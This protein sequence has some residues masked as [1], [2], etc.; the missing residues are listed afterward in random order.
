MRWEQLF[1]DLEAQL[2]AAE[3]RDQAA[4][5]ADRTR[6]ERS[7]VGLGE[8]LLGQRDREVRLALR[9]GHDVAGVVVDAG[10]GWVLVREPPRVAA[11]VPLAAVEL[12]RG[13]SG[14]TAGPTAAGRAAA[15]AKRFGLGFALRALSRD[16]A[17]VAVGLS[18]GRVLTGTIDA[19]GADAFDL[20]EH[21]A[22]LPRRDRHV[23]ATTVLAVAAVRVV[24]SR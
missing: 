5:V 7:L 11:L 13:L 23:V 4:E 10:E 20:S 17:T 9:G 21:A 24:R 6:R 22:D 12:A 1:A 8:R 14:P 19:V 15:R 16:R 3:L 2:A 18:G